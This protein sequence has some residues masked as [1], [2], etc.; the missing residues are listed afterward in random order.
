MADSILTIGHS[1]HPVESFLTL[2]QR[3][4][5]TAL[6]DIRSRPYSR[7][8]PQYNRESLKKTLQNEEIQYV[9]LGKELGGR[10]HSPDC[11]IEG[12]LSYELLIMKAYFQEGISRLIDGMKTYQ[13][14]IMCAEKDPLHCHRTTLV[15][16]ALFHRG[17]TV[18]HIHGDGELE[19]YPESAGRLMDI[20]GLDRR[21]MYTSEAEMM[22]IALTQ[23]ANRMRNK[24]KTS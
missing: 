17:I 20:L 13:V 24:K 19:D 22:D 14:A 1:N 15:G 21:D 8:Y 7:R 23:Q 18:R 5:V 10:S 2:L 16:R 12:R 9:Y 11:Y 3:H 6:A 4:G